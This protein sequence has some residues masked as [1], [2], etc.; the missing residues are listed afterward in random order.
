MTDSGHGGARQRWRCSAVGE[1]ECEARQRMS[2][3]ER[4]SEC[5]VAPSST[6]LRPDVCGQRWHTDAKWW[7]WPMVSQPQWLLPRLVQTG[8]GADR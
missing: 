7:P 5:D 6:L 8:E 4:V 1:N 3:R 2:E